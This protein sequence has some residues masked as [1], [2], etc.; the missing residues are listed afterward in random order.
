MRKK[1]AELTRQ[2]RWDKKNMV[3]ISTRLSKKDA[4]KFVEMCKNE[5]K[6]VYTWLREKC[7]EG[8][9]QGR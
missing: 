3:T 1:D 4:E 9:R 8:I 5:H 7:L 6:T 2:Q